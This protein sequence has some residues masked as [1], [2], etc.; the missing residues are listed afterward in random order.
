MLSG[1]SG[2][3]SHGQIFHILV[4]ARCGAV[5]QSQRPAKA[6]LRKQQ[7]VTFSPSSSP[8]LFLSLSVPV[9]N[10]PSAGL[11]PQIPMDR[12][13]EERECLNVL[14]DGVEC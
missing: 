3:N 8:S 2:I 9:V 4:C 12:E 14:N 10:N 5:A 6:N 1:L 11:Y 7:T 13:S